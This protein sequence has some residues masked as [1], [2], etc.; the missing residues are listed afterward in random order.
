M[1]W[2]WVSLESATLWLH[3]KNPTAILLHSQ[4]RGGESHDM[5]LKES[6]RI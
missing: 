2:L 6:R 1:Q 5:V 4:V 3:D